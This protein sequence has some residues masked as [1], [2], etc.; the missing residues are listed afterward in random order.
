MALLSANI[1]LCEFVL[2]ERNDIP[3]M[4]R[5]MSTIALSPTR[6]SAHF[7]AVTTVHCQPG[8][9]GFH[10]L[11]VGV[12]EGG[13]FISR[14]PPHSFQYGYKIDPSGAGGFILTSEFNLDVSQLRLPMN[15][16]VCAYLDTLPEPVAKTPLM[17]RRA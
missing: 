15:D 14:T 8:D 3:T 11:L 4:V 1:L 12:S 13:N 7:F 10:S 5:T 2:W 17:I 9:F 6:Q 16:F